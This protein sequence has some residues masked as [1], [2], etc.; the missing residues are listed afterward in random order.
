MKSL[1]KNL[2]IFSTNFVHFGRGI[3][4]VEMELTQMEPQ[5]I[6]NLGNW[7]PYTQ[8]E[9]YSAKTPIKIMKVMERAS[10][11]YKVHYNPMTVPKPPEEIQRLMFP[12]IEQCNISF[13]A[14]YASHPRPAACAL[15]GFM[16]RGRKLLL[17]Y[18]TQLM[19]IGHTH[20]LFDNEVFN[21]ELF[22]N[23]RETLSTFCRI[24]VN[25]VSWP[26]G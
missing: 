15:I 18:V 14:L 11:K 5:Y 22:L 20:I 3:G 17:Q 10:E 16:D 8:Y 21:N 4:P 9:F 6:K 7:K 25:P 19:N 13:N 24:I 12:F 1:F 23:C 2:K 26:R